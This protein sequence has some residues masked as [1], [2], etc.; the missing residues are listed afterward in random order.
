[1]LCSAQA[2]ED[3]LIRIVTDRLLEIRGVAQELGVRNLALFGSAAGGDFDPTRSDLDFV[4]EFPPLP[5]EEHARR[6]FELSARLE[7]LFQRR[8]DLVELR[9]I[10]NPHLRA[11]IERTR[12]QLFDAA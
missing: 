11:E 2:E 12:V 9:P 4:V 5:P 1:M 6:F 3:A 8:V 10:R 7:G